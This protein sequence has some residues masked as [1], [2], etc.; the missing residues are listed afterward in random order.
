VIPTIGLMIGVYILFRFSETIALSPSRYR[1]AAANVT[2]IVFAIVGWLVVAFCTID[3]MLSG[4]KTP[5]L[6]QE[7]QR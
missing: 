6:P 7:N 4:T 5:G 1:N 3:L 2:I